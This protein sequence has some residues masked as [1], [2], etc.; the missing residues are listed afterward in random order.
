[1]APNGT[2]QLAV[3][4]DD[5]YSYFTGQVTPGS[6]EYTL[7]QEITGYVDQT[8]TDPTAVAV[9]DENT[10]A[11]AYRND[12]DTPKLRKYELPAARSA[13]PFVDVPLKPPTS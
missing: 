4:A 5:G 1:M 9:P 2:L 13:V 11:I 6:S 12:L 3:R 8:S 7:W 10:W